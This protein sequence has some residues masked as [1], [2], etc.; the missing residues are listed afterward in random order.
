MMA[1]YAQDWIGDTT[2]SQCCDSSMHEERA[3]RPCC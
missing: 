3:R 2:H 1:K